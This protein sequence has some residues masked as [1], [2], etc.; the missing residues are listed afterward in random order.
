L[1]SNDL[2]SFYFLTLLFVYFGYKAK[3]T[4]AIW[5]QCVVRGGVASLGL[6]GFL[7]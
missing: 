3:I 7:N 1:I 4:A 5:Q 2:Q 6:P